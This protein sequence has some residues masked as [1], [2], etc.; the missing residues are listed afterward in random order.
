MDVAPGITANIP[1]DFTK[2]SSRYKSRAW[3]ALVGLIG[4]I[5][6]YLG[7]AIW[8]A[9][10]CYRL[11]LAAINNPSGG[12]WFIGLG[13]GFLSVFL[14]KALV[15]IQ[16][17][18]PSNDIE[19]KAS[20]QSELFAFI[21]ALADEIKA[22]RP[23]R[24]YLSPR[25]NAAVF[26]DLSLLNFVIPSRKNL[27]IGLALVNILNVGE[28]KAVLAHEFGHFAQRTM[29]VGRW[30]YIAQQIAAHIVA[31]RD[32]LDK[33]LHTISRLDI[34]IAWV[35][36]IFRLLVWSIRSLVEVLFMGVLLAEKALSREMEFQAD[37]VSVSVT[38]SDA[39]IHA[40]HKLSAADDAWVRAINFA[41]A[42]KAA[43]RCTSDIFPLQT[44][45]LDRM[46]NLL[47][48]PNYGI[49]PPCASADRAAFRVFKSSLAAPPQMW[50][51]H[52]SNADREEN[53]KRR[54][55]AA[56]IDQRSAWL[57]F[58]N[59]NSLKAAISKL[60]LGEV[61]AS[62]PTLPPDQLFDRLDQQYRMSY[63]DPAYHGVYFNRSTVRHANSMPEL[64]APE[65]S[66]ALASL[67]TLYPQALSTDVERR[68]ALQEESVL[69]N[70]ILNGTLK[71]SGDAI[72]FRGREVTHRELPALA[73]KVDTELAIFDDRLRQHDRLCRATHM[74]LART[75]NTVHDDGTTARAGW[76][77]YL[78]GLLAVHHYATHA[79][80]ILRDANAHYQ[81]IFRHQV[82]KRAGQ[83]ANLDVILAAAKIPY[84]ALARIH[85]ESGALSLDATLLARLSTPSWSAQLQDLKLSEPSKENLP[86]WVKVA[87]GW[88][89]SAI[90]NIGSLRF[91]AF[92]QLL[93]TERLMVTS[94]QLCDSA[95]APAPA[96]NGAL[97][98][99]PTPSV[100]PADYPRLMPGD[101]ISNVKPDWKTRL[102]GDGA[103]LPLF[104]RIGV[105]AAIIGIAIYTAGGAGH[106]SVTVYNGLGLPVQVTIA[107]VT[108][109]VNAFAHQRIDI[110]DD[111]TV[112]VHAAAGG[113]LIE[114]FD[115]KVT[116]RGAHDVYNIAGAGVLVAWTAN[117]GNVGKIPPRPLGAPR[118]MH[119]PVDHEFE[120]PPT[121]ITSKTGGGT[122]T[123]L[124][125]LSIESPEQLLG[126]LKGNREEMIRVI[127]LHA[128]WDLPSAPYKQQW[129]DLAQKISGAT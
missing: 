86:N 55:I 35:G 38:G 10:T 112:H 17:A 49:T 9:W 114:D 34:R 72:R 59:A 93:D 60:L 96:S 46:R 28:L 44:R 47:S 77:D 11:I 109:T 90:S 73:A 57:L 32:A 99:A 79:E 7:M 64:Y 116:G 23:Y 39:L 29:A 121:S 84:R 65:P 51:T 27:E 78:R 18:K 20:D 66:N 83:K 67:R 21:Y 1:S 71:K 105:A 75:I 19:L 31:K 74:A 5:T 68:R 108:T 128:N 42:E 41:S 91:I 76:P 61:P 103:P 113:R 58:K 123:V 126:A 117:Y 111:P 6:I 26:Y 48:D 22:P 129:S 53:A 118:W 2:P 92:E 102:F 82:T 97:G 87:D 62:A 104:M 8:L 52:P 106:T 14:F 3:I 94:A 45:V 127:R 13:A 4:F 110:P 70:G 25:V 16:R 89:N 40:L 24:I 85:A 122:R 37:L 107:N 100:V 63:L 30:V 33:L 119:S 88:F 15:F 95:A 101:E 124:S 56:D 115:A 98:L 43:G 81:N 50:S 125:G 120:Q 12:S 54:Y 36:W 69:L 80:A